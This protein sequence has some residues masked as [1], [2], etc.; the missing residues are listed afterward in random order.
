MKR[1]NYVLWI[2]DLVRETLD[3]PGGQQ[4]DEIIGIDMFVLPYLLKTLID[5][6]R[7]RDRC[8]C[9]LSSTRSENGALLEVC[10]DR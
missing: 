10:R 8:F 7:K 6:Y 2:Q 1:L 4:L 3:C 9:N 5:H